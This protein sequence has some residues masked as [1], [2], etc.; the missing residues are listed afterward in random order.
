VEFMISVMLIFS[1]FSH[2]FPAHAGFL[3]T[4][5]YELKLD[6]S[7]KGFAPSEVK[8]LDIQNSKRMASNS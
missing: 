5:D 8:M 7:N 4:C 3:G 1:R 2:E 6:Y